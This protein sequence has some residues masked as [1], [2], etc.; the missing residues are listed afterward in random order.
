MNRLLCLF[1][2]TGLQVVSVK[3]YEKDFFNSYNSTTCV[4]TTV[5]CPV[6]GENYLDEG[7]G[8][9]GTY[10]YAANDNGIV[11]VRS[12]EVTITKSNL[13]GGTGTT[14]CTQS[15]SRTLDD[16]GKEDC[17][18]GHILAHSLGGPGNQPINI[19]PQDAHVNRG[20]W[21]QYEGDIY[22]CLDSGSAD[23]AKLSWKFVYDKTT[24]TK[25]ISA[26]YSVDYSG[27]NKE[28]PECVDKSEEFTNAGR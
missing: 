23:S 16:D 28:D 5:P 10:S 7:G 1:L 2:Y 12:A 18:A 14:S 20:E 9:V 15:Y 26:T 27:G 6:E 4:C 24:D 17:D 25:P 11:I 8:G 22:D 3:G 21:A 19:F 13:D